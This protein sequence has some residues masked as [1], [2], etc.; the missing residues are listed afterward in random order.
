MDSCPEPNV[1]GEGFDVEADPNAKT[2]GTFEEVHDS[3]KGEEPLNA[4]E[5]EV[6]APKLKGVMSVPKQEKAST[7][8]GLG[9]V[10]PKANISVVEDEP[11]NI[12]VVEDT[13]PAVVESATAPKTENVG[14]PDAAGEGEHENNDVKGLS[15]E[16]FAAGPETNEDEIAGAPN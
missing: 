11:A 7:V 10:A 6:V 3:N 16:E 12:W 13:E 9:W 15:V 5:E 4:V 2:C 8:N 14:V 1:K